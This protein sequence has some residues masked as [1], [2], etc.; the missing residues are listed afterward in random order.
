MKNFMIYLSVLLL[1]FSL[2][3]SEKHCRLM[4]EGFDRKNKQHV[5]QFE[6]NISSKMS[7]IYLKDYPTIKASVT[8]S[9]KTLKIL[10]KFKSQIYNKYLSSRNSLMSEDNYQNSNKI[11]ELK[12]QQREKILKFLETETITQENVYQLLKD[13]PEAR[14]LDFEKLLVLQTEYQELLSKLLTLKKDLNSLKAPHFL[15]VPQS[16]IHLR[17]NGIVYGNVQFEAFLRPPSKSMFKIPVIG[18]G[19]MTDESTVIY[20]CIHF[21]AEDPQE[22]AVYIYFLKTNKV[23]GLKWY[24]YL[25]N[26]KLALRELFTYRKPPQATVSPIE[27]NY[28][29][30]TGVLGPIDYL[31]KSVPALNAFSFLNNFL[32]RLSIVSSNI[33][34]VQKFVMDNVGIGIKGLLIQPD[35]ISVSYGASTFF[36]LLNFDL[37]KQKQGADFTPYMNILTK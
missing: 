20:S 24:E 8:E 9:K 32:Q 16:D 12:A 35:Q 25:A 31:F 22:N 13:I 36:G 5:K 37:I 19:F 34:P 4:P 6:K 18:A 10:K 14:E 28:D 26:Y 21:D 23:F 3:A 30:L 11:S 33:N 1:S 2:Y 29:P 7:E 15:Y 17:G 27:L